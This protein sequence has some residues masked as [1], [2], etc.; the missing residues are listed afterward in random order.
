MTFSTFWADVRLFLAGVVA[1]VAA[2]PKTFL[3][4]SVFAVV[5][6]LIF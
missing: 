4:L 6:A 1:L 2:N 5:V 3:I